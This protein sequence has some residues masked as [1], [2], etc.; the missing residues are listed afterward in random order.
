MSTAPLPWA[1]IDDADG[2]ELDRLAAEHGFHELDV[3]DCRHGRQTAK[4]AEHS[5]YSFVVIKT[6]DY[7]RAAGE[8]NFH[9]FDLF[10]S[11]SFLVTVAEGKAEVVPAALERVRREAQ[12]RQPNGIAYLLIDHAV[13]QYMPVLDEIGDMIGDLEDEVIERPSPRVLDRIF[14]L[15]RML[16]DFRRNATAMR[17]VLN[18]LTRTTRQEQTNGLFL[19]YRDI[20]DHLVRTLDFIESYRDLLTG[21]LDIYLSALANRTNNVMKLLTVWGT[22]SIPLVVVTSFYGM[23]LRLPLQDNPH[24][25]YI[26][27]AGLGALSA[28]LLLYSRRKGW[29]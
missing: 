28:W 1:H 27:L 26:L 2:P 6:I 17:E 8:L 12:F 18:H 9:D 19:Y 15:K 7:D 20:Y 13:D 23:N 16:I 21:S 10:V 4:V 5:D 24:A 29:L 22:I 14:R 3:E 11:P 25:V